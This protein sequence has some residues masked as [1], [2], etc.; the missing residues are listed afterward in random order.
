[1]LPVEYDLVQF[2]KKMHPTSNKGDHSDT[3][4]KFALNIGINFL[5]PEEFYL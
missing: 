3:D 2:K 4:F 1:M 5:T